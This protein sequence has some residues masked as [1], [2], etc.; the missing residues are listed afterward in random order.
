M[1]N[2]KNL[3]LGILF[4]LLSSTSMAQD[5]V[6]ID[7]RSDGGADSI[8]NR[9]FINHD[10]DLSDSTNRKTFYIRSTPSFDEKNGILFINHDLD[11]FDSTGGKIL[12]RSIPSRE[13]KAARV[14]IKKSGLFRKNKIV[15]DFDPA[16]HHIVK[17]TDNGNDVPISKFHKYQDYLEEANDFTE[18]EALHPRME[19]LEW[20]MVVDDLSDSVKIAKIEY[21]L[22]DLENLKSDRAK[23]KKE[24]FVS[25]KKILELD[26]LAETIQKV[27][28]ESGMT[29]PQKI[30]EIKIKD[31]I[32]F[33]NG[34]EITGELGKKCIAV[35]QN[36]VNSDDRK[37]KGWKQESSSDIHIIFD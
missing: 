31:E 10:F 34:E 22:Q 32:F 33:L 7:M 5:E 2:Q 21:V 11:S 17:V 19:E 18:L 37:I 15:I 12:L 36:H 28:E 35:C 16:T 1:Q 30:K 8:F 23:F 24:H 4:I 6:I 9:I 29:P 25:I 13:K 14:V 20:N 26:E 3:I 27:L